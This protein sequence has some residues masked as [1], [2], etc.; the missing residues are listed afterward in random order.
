MRSLS[1]GKNL[2]GLIHGKM[3]NECTEGGLG[4]KN[5]SISLRSQRMITR[6]NLCSHWAY[7]EFIENLGKKYFLTD[8]EGKGREN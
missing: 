5:V 2:V 7:W 3:D 4:R 6:N 1:R 8:R